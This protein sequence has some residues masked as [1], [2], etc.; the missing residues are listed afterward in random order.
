MYSYIRTQDVKLRQPLCDPDVLRLTR[1][2]VRLPLPEN[3]LWQLGER[4]HESF[5]LIV[6]KCICSDHRA[7]VEVDNSVFR[8]INVV[9]NVLQ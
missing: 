3:P 8:S 6:W 1:H 4:L 9:L 2:T 7:H 5:S